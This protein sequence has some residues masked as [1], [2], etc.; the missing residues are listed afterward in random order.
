M[1]AADLKLVENV[2]D[3]ILDR[4]QRN[5]Q[6][7]SDFFVGGAGDDQAQ[8]IQLPICQGECLLLIG[9]CRRCSPGELGR[10]Y[11]CSRWTP[12]RYYHLIGRAI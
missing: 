6:L 9:L 1:T 12:W 2:M 8:Y 11:A 3:V 10:R 5:M 4:V 7:G